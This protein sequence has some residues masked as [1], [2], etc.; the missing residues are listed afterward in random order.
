MNAEKTVDW[1]ISSQAPRPGEGSTIIPQGSRVERPEA[2]GTPR[3]NADRFFAKVD[4]ESSPVFWNGTRCHE[5][6]SCIAK[7]EYGQFSHKCKTYYAHRVAWELDKGPVP[8]GERV[9]HYC[10][11]RRCVNLEHLFTG[12]TQDNSDDMKAKRRQAHGVRV[13]GAK[14]DD[15]SVRNIRDSLEDQAVLAERFGVSQGTISMVRTGRIW[16]HVE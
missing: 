10:D 3:F 6:C 14:L 5:W 9:L 7:N 16:R 1:A 15:D 12:S 4:T 13:H 11:N 2:R 8:E